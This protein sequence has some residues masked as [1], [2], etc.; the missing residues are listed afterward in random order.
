M[1][2]GGGI[3]R[4]ASGG[5]CEELPEILHAPVDIAADVIGVI[6]FH[7]AGG[8]QVAGQ[9]AVAEARREALNLCLD[10]RR[11]IDR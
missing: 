4:Q 7:V 11:H 10:T 9:D 3:G 8:E 1:P 6:R 5:P 2:G